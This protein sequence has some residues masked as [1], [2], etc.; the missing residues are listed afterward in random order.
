VGAFW[1][2]TLYDQARGAR[3]CGRR[4]RTPLAAR[5]ARWLQQGVSEWVLRAHSLACPPPAAVLPGTRPLPDGP[6]LPTSPPPSPRWQAG[7]QVPNKLK[8]YAIGSRDSLR[9]APDGTVVLY[10]QVCPSPPASIQG[11]AA[12]PWAPSPH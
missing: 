5:L 11:L 4:L 9:A 7:Y 12:C 10:I 8:R 6:A 2:L 1:S 3:A